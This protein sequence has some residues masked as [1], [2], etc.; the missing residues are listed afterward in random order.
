[1][2]RACIALSLLMAMTAVTAH[3]A[4]PAPAPEPEPTPEPAPAPEPAPEPEPAPTPEP[5]PPVEVPKQKTPA[6]PPP[7]HLAARTPVVPVVRVVHHGLFRFRPEMLVANDLGPG[8]SPVPDPLGLSTGVDPDAAALA[9][10]SIRLRYEPTLLIGSGLGVHLGVDLLDNLV[11]G[12]HP[13]AAGRPD[14]VTDLLGDS[15]APPSS[16]SIGWRDALTVRQA[17]LRWNAFDTFDVRAGRMVDHYGLGISRNDGSCDDCDFGTVVDRLAIGFSIS[18]FR[19]DA[20]W[21][22][23]AVGATSDLAFAHERQPFGQAKDLG[24]EDDVTTYTVEVGRYPVTDAELRER[25]LALDERREWAID[26]SIFSAFTDQTLSSSEPLAESSFECASSGELANGQP[27]TS[28]DCLRLFRR[29]AFFWR[30]GAWFR[31]EHRPAHDEQIRVELELAGIFGEIESPQ[32]LVEDVEPKTFQGLGVAAEL[33]WRRAWLGLGVDLGLATGDDG[34]HLGVLDGQDVVDPDDD[35]YA[36]N[37]ALR[38]NGTITSFIFNR[39]Y[40]LDL[41]LF[42]Q[43]IGAVTNAAYIK[44]WIAGEVLRSEDLTL[45]LRLDVLYAMAMRPSGTP[46]DGRHWGLE[47]DARVVLETVDGFTASLASGILLPFDALADPLTGADAEP[48]GAVRALFGWR[49]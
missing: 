19:I 34:E 36:T 43:V 11:L 13:L 31:A 42:R 12:S 41:V 37:D 47:V 28:Y 1:M 33:E 4:E 27:L 2:S 3:A 46:G 48:A 6:A 20:S 7:E 38:A 26:W 39:D 23:S 8:V 18:G 15:Q 24:Q 9:W 17:F 10:A 5:L 40:H 14:L 44:P 49:F 21:E 25:Q 30:P 22:Y 32:R 29:G 45:S 16:G 35:A